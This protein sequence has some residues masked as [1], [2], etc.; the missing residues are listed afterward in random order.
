MCPKAAHKGWQGQLAKSAQ[1]QWGCLIIVLTLYLLWNNNES[2][3]IIFGWVSLAD[4]D[5][6]QMCKVR[7]DL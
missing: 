5:S 2:F 7:G 4:A 1:G 3:F 6:Q